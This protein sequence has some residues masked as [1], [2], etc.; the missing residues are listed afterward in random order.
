MFG[1]LHLL[2]CGLWLW[3]FAGA[4]VQAAIQ[5]VIVSSERSE[6]YAAASQA[7]MT[8]LERDG[9]S[10][11]EVMDMLASEIQEAASL[12][13]KL[14]IALGSEAANVMANLASRV[15]VLCALLPRASFE[16]ALVANGRR[17]SSQ[18]SAVFL[19][20]PLGRQL[21]LI[22]LALPQKRRVGVLWGVESFNQAPALKAQAKSRGMELV[23][24][25]VGRDEVVFD[26]LKTVLDRSDVLLAIPDPN[27][28][29]SN[30]IQNL[31]LSSFR[32]R[33]PMVAFAPAYVRAG[34][35]MALHV[36]PS[37]IGQQAGA[38]ARGVLQGKSLPPIPVYS[39]S[40]S[41]SVNEHVA[42]SLALKLDVEDLQS[43][44]RMRES[45]P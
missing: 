33:I 11:T 31:L 41:I 40:F 12:N 22:Q 37:Q 27:I 35:L 26:G 3:I 36:T 43:R 16:R 28:Y 7:V 44:L 17:A 23:E 9:I 20:Q 2:I 15:P 19:D 25:A 29:N 39:Q 10:K 8:E 45:T 14:F 1:R 13:P 18:F 5:V 30:G 42:R 38:M 24:A 4:S 34:A 21:D 32:A 6:A